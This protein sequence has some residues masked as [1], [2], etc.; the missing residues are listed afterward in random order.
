MMQLRRKNFFFFFLVFTFSFS[1]SLYIYI[2]KKKTLYYQ[3][4]CFSKNIPLNCMLREDHYKDN[5]QP[6]Q[7]PNQP[8][9]SLA[10]TDNEATVVTSDAA[11]VTATLNSSSSTEQSSVL[12]KSHIVL[13]NH[14]HLFFKSLSKLYYKNHCSWSHCY[15][16]QPQL[17][18]SIINR[19]RYTSGASYYQN[20]I[21]RYHH[22]YLHLQHNIH[23]FKKVIRRFSN[24]RP[25]SNSATTCQNKP[26]IDSSPP[27][28]PSPVNWTPPITYDTLKELS[29]NHIFKSL[30][31]RHDLLFDPNLSFRPNLDGPSGRD[32]RKKAERYW[33]RVDRAFEQQHDWTFLQV[34]IQE[35]C[36]ILVSLMHPIASYPHIAA[37]VSGHTA[38]PWHWPSY[39]TKHHIH[40][41]LD[42]D[43][44]I[45]QLKYSKH[46]GN[47]VDWLRSTFE[48]LL[49]Q[50]QPLQQPQQQQHQQH[51]QNTMRL[52]DTMVRYFA[53]G[54]YAK[55]LKQCFAILEAIK[56]VKIRK[57]IIKKKET[58]EKLIANL[59]HH[60]DI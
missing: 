1:F 26:S 8:S 52:I 13:P 27:P 16:R 59:D 12:P 40:D 37:V 48:S 56:L 18:S 30:Q 36:R 25:I 6:N 14:H 51:Q 22:H 10:D 35:L 2:I 44:I 38:L 58:K 3:D 60:L 39:I 46:I 31:L 5:Q 53:E 43:L 57:E 42:S 19:L 21:K 55:A 11:I 15:Y 34:I 23:L 9:Q 7:Q 24:K 54:K 49:L 32:K 17:T 28:P 29:V 20:N 33:R 41:V 4:T 45:Q 50:P 47:Q